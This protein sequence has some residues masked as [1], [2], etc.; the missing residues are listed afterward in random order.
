MSAATP[1]SKAKLSKLEVFK[2]LATYCLCGTGV[3]MVGTAVAIFAFQPFREV[4]FQ[5]FDA[6]AID[7]DWLR[8]LQ[9]T[10]RQLM[11]MPPNLGGG[12]AG[13]CLRYI[14]LRWWSKAEQPLGAASACAS[15]GGCFILLALGC[16]A[17][18]GLICAE[19]LGQCA[20][21]LAAYMVCGAAFGFLTTLAAR[22]VNRRLKLWPAA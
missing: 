6:A 17:A 13:L 2:S 3:G 4:N 11:A 16:M 9:L 21:F 5:N 20:F 15:L 10:G 18:F 8:V 19:E 1:E 14:S 22:G 12:V 7:M